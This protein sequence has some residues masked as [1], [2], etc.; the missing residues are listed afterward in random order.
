M[1]ATRVLIIDDNALNIELAT[2]VLEE[3][4]FIVESVMQASELMARVASFRPDLILMDIQL[5]GSDGLTLTRLLKADPG[6][7]GIAVAAFTAYAMK[8]DEA[9]MRAAGCDGYIAKPIEVESLVEQIRAILQ[10]ARG[11]KE[12]TGSFDEPPRES[13]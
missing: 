8:G 4:S 2:F 13:R 11:D 12:G 5:P 9:K 10:L 1:T 3:A 6:T 7:R